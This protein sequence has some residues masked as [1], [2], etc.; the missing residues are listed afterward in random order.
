MPQTV[1]KYD[2]G[3]YYDKAEGLTREQLLDLIKNISVPEKSYIFPKDVNNRSFRRVWLD[4]YSWLCYSPSNYG[5]YCLPC[6]LV[7]L[8]F[9]DGCFLC[10]TSWAT[11]VKQSCAFFC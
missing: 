1:S 2:V 8:H 9:Q 5:G 6:T 11:W 7:T 4:D 3:T 10:F